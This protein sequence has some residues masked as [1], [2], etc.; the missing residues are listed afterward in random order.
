MTRGT[1]RTLIIGAGQAGLALAYHLTS[2]GLPFMILEQAPQLGRTWDDRW[3]SL[4]LFT[5]RQYDSLP[6]LAFPGAAD[7]YPGKDDVAAYLR[8]Y[9]QHHGLPVQLSTRVEHLEACGEGF[10]AHTDR[11]VVE[12]DQVVV[13]TGAFQT[14]AVPTA[15][16]DVPASV[17]QL[18][19]SAYRN[20]AQLPDGDVVVV[21][22]GNTG[23]QLALDLAAHRQVTLSVGRRNRAVSQRPLGRDL[24]WWFT[25]LGVMRVRADSRIGRKAQATELLVGVGPE[26]LRRHGVRVVGR[27]AGAND[28]ELTFDDGERARPAAVIWATGYR[29]DH[30]WIDVPGVL[31]ASGSLSQR[32]G[33]TPHPRLHT[34]GLPWQRSRGS[35]LLGFVGADADR[36]ADRLA[37]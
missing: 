22:A 17:T 35:A 13:A 34:L 31:G 12:A 18:H 19:S 5:P 27:F 21:G 24:F 33:L 29:N 16:A 26:E 25:R 6:G 37:A 8:T 32:D 36:L 7:T 1:R 15:G 11:G 3:E 20:A 9:A 30:R 2:R 14:P 4:R 28:G 10:R 23:V